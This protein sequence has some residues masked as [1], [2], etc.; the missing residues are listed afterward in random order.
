MVM[1]SP[2]DFDADFDRHM[3]AE[4]DAV[5]VHERFGL[6]NAVGDLP[7]RGARD[8]FTLIVDKLNAL[9]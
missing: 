5:V 8:F 4:V 7:H 6:I 1:S 2:A 9:L 3:L